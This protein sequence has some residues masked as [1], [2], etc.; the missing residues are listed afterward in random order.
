VDILSAVG[1]D[2]DGREASDLLGREGVNVRHLKQCTLQRGA[3]IR[4]PDVTLNEDPYGERKA[5]LNY[6]PRIEECY[7]ASQAPL[8]DEAFDIIFLTLEFSEKV[9]RP[10]SAALRH[11]RRTSKPL[12]VLNPAPKREPGPPTP[13]ITEFLHCADILT[14]NR[15]EAAFLTGEGVVDR[16]NAELAARVLEIHGVREAYVT[17]G[18]RGWSWATEDGASTATMGVPAADVVDKVGASDVFTAVLGIARAL[19]V[20]P[21]VASRAGGLAARLAVGRPGGAE[22]FPSGEELA[23]ELRARPDDDESL[24]L[25][26]RISSS[27]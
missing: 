20:S 8:L 2:S 7:L 17:C 25:A 18:E 24:R 23:R 19:D 5:T 13:I 12:I 14:P 15:F 6:D 4:T 9:L 10:L 22:A 21:R 3:S 1:G 16:P 11:L 26:E 27:E